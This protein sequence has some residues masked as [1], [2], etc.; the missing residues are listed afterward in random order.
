MKNF[1]LTISIILVCSVVYA[2]QYQTVKRA[3]DGGILIEAV[4]SN[5][6]VHAGAFHTLTQLQTMLSRSTN[7]L[8]QKDIQEDIDMITNAQTNSVTNSVNS[9]GD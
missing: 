6:V 2:V 8:V 7:P 3:Q 1:I 5:G 9:T 4:D